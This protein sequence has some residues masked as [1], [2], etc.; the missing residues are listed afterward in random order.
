MLSHALP[1]VNKTPPPRIGGGK[2]RTRGLF[3]I[4]QVLRP[5]VLDR[6]RVRKASGDSFGIDLRWR[7]GRLLF[8]D[9]LLGIEHLAKHQVLDTLQIGKASRD[10]PETIPRQFVGRLFGITGCI[11]LL[12]RRHIFL[13]C[14]KKITL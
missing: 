4:G 13:L 10:E 7:P 3:G 1:S 6:I 8:V 12:T 2:K 14:V 11:R 9:I 5:E